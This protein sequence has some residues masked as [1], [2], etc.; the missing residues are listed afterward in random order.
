[1]LQEIKNTKGYKRLSSLLKKGL[2]RRSIALSMSIGLVVGVL[3]L[4]FVNTAIVAFLSILLRLNLP[5]ALFCC[6][7]ITPLHIILF[8]P[9]IKMG[10]WLLSL[11]HSFLTMDK[12]QSAFS[13]SVIGALKELSFELAYGVMA[14]GVCA[15][16]AACI[17][18]YLFYAVF[19]SRSVQEVNA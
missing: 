1:M 12:I 17:L 18:Y 10:E 16:P 7:A 14:W 3:P 5:L 19:K 15:L 11:E 8:I 4:F 2:S 9:F 13:E 6:Y